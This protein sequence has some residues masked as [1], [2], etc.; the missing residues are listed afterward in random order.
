[1]QKLTAPGTGRSHRISEVDLLLGSWHPGT[2]PA[3]REVSALPWRALPE[4][5][6][7][8]SWFLDPTKSSLQK[9]E[10]GLQKLTALKLTL[11]QAFIF[12]QE[13]GPN[14]RYLCT[15]PARGEIACRECSNHWNSRES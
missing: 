2:F 7:E 6:R 14:A 11:F 10:C 15:I 9:W 1:V 8:P 12:C 5:L 13:A 3:R 4:H